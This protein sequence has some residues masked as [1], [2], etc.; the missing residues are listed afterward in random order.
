MAKD[1][2]SSATVIANLTGS[3]TA[4]EVVS[5]KTEESGPVLASRAVHGGRM[6][7]FG[8]STGD[9]RSGSRSGPKGRIDVKGFTWCDVTL[10]NACHRCGHPS[11]IAA[12]CMYTMPEHVKE[13][14]ISTTSRSRSRSP[15]RHTHHSQAHHHGHQ[16]TELEHA[17]AA[18]TADLDDYNYDTY[19]GT[20]PLLI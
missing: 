8:S 14:I 11:H 18:F 12:R 9:V 13:W 19:G 7:R 1:E 5:I 6:G 4:T 2:P 17:G 10:P 16:A 3:A 15:P 20:S